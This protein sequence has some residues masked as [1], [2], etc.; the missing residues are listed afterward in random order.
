ML[1]R[2]SLRSLAVA[3]LLALVVSAS[4]A[5]APAQLPAGVLVKV[6]YYPMPG[7]EQDVVGGKFVASNDP[8]LPDETI[9]SSPISLDK[10]PVRGQIKSAPAPGEWGELDFETNTTPYRWIAYAAPPGSHGRIAEVEFYSRERK[11]FGEPFNAFSPHAASRY[12][13]DGDIKSYYNGQDADNQ[14]AGLDIGTLATGRSPEASPLQGEFHD[15][16]TVALSCQTPGAVIRYTLDGALPGVTSGTLYTAPI[17]VSKTTTVTAI[18]FS[19][20]RAPTPPSNNTYIIGAP[21]HRTLFQIGNSLTQVGGG[22]RDHALTAGRPVDQQIFGIGGARTKLLWEA[23][24]NTMDAASAA[25]FTGVQDRWQKTWGSLAKIDDFTMQPRDFDIAE[26]ADYDNRFMNL[27]AQKSPEVQPWLYI[28]WTEMA[29]QRPTDLGAEPTG[30]M[31]K[32]WPAATWEESMGGM[33]L[34]GEDLK[35]KV[36]ETYKGE[37]PVRIIP[38]ALAMGWLHYAVEHGQFPG[39]APGQFY[40]KLFRD[41]VHP[42]TEGAFLVECTWYAAIYGESPEGRILP[43]NTNLTAEQARIMAR[44]AWDAVKNYPAAGYYEEGTSPAGKP[45]FSAGPAANGLVPVTLQSA[46]PGA[47]FRYTMDGTTPTRTRGLI[48]CGAVTARPGVTLKAIGYKSGMADSQVSQ[49]SF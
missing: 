40:P 13:T 31:T 6:R 23:A 36:D 17:P 42:N 3:T 8:S 9:N 24:T 49:I 19:D 37:K 29:R 11:L 28:E 21:A 27:V 47:W 32:A 30:E 10:F 16:L 44:M 41:D 2:D 35:R 15:P 22:Y 46:S 5:P 1:N 14:F 39:V 4:A 12:A 38:T 7:H 18:A 43:I 33:I 45:E 25:K 34:Y 20:N 26:E 48:Y